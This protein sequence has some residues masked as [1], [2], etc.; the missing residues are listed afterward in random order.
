MMMTGSHRVILIAAVVVLLVAAAGCR[1]T[2]VPCSSS[3]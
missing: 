3:N 2:S 1:G